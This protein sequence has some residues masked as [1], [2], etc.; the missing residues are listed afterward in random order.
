MWLNYKFREYMLMILNYING[1]GRGGFAKR[2][3]AAKPYILPPLSES[4]EFI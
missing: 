4:Y 2:K 1:F 3:R